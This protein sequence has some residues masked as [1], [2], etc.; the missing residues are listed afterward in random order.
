MFRRRQTSH[1]FLSSCLAAIF[2]VFSLAL[3]TRAVFIAISLAC[4]FNLEKS[5]AACIAANTDLARVRE[6]P[7]KKNVA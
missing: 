7:L 2:P 3:V 5:P 4:A 6:F 1:S